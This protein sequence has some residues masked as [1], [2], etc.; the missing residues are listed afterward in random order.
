MNLGSSLTNATYIINHGNTDMI[1]LQSQSFIY[2]K[3]ILFWKQKITKNGNITVFTG[4]QD[5][6]LYNLEVGRCG[7]LIDE[8]A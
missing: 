7:E 6:Q 8:K 3:I 5:T 2:Y 4:K 1:I